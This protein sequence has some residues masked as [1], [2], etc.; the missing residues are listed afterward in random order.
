M[1]Y[2]KNNILIVLDA[3][4]L[5]KHTVIRM[6]LDV[7]FKNWKIVYWN[8]LNIINV[9][10]NKSYN[11]KGFRRIVRKNFIEI[12]AF[13]DLKHELKKIPSKFYYANQ[14]GNKSIFSSLLDRYLN[15]KGGKKIYIH[16][17]LDPELKITFFEVF[18]D[19][20]IKDKI[21]LLK[22]IINFIR[23]KIFFKIN[24]HIQAKPKILFAGNNF[25]YKLFK[26][27]ITS[28]K[29]FKIDSAEFEK[30]SKFGSKIKNKNYLLF[31]DQVLEGSFDHKLN[32]LGIRKLNKKKY[33]DNLDKIFNTFLSRYKNSKFLVAAHPRRNILDKPINKKF[34]FDKTYNLVKNSK[35]VFAHTSLSTK[36]AVLL[37][38]PIVFITMDMFKLLTFGNIKTA[39]VYS[40]LLGT[41][42]INVNDKF[43]L[44]SKQI[45]LNKSISIDKKKYKKFAEEYI[46][47]PG[48]K[49]QGRW[50]K[51]LKVLE[52]DNFIK[53]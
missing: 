10:I 43:F 15:Y 33:W 42:I 46:N 48:L 22:K 1:Y 32:Y 25:T 49:P 40:K 13:Q 45:R 19:L 16:P 38:K 52:Q 39:E 4:P 26:K 3:N 12:N 51:I 21:F 2:N 36:Y 9:N 8:L 20:I 50:K 6:G 17:G 28:K 34:I 37:K 5:T 53:N 23:G 11:T 29:I 31:L 47:F 7:K 30:Y 41:N 35:I 14:V 18:K 27:K 44:R 24:E